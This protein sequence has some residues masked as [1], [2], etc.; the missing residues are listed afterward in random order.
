MKKILGRFLAAI[1]R[2]FVRLFNIGI[3][4]KVVLILILLVGGG[5]FWMTRSKMLEKVGGKEDYDEAMR[6][7][8]IKD[9]VQEHYIDE[10]DRSR[11]GQ[12]A[13][14]AMIAGLGDKW[15]YFMTPDE[16]KSYKLSSANEYSG[17]G[18]SISK[19][20]NGNFRVISVN[21]G[22]AA[23]E[24]G[25]SAGMLLSSVDGENIRGLSEDQARTL[26]RSKLNGK[27]TLGISGGDEL[28]VDC[29]RTHE[30]AVNYRK[31]KTDAGY[32]Q[33]YNFEA[34]SADEAI[35]AIERLLEQNIVALC[36]D[37]RGNAGGLAGETQKL[38][39]YLL[40]AGTLFYTADRKGNEEAASSDSMCIQLPMVVLLNSETYAEAEVFAACMQEYQW[41][42]LFGETTTGSTRDQ[43]TIELSDGSAIRLSTKSYLTP[44]HVDISVKGGVVPDMILYNSDPSTAGTTQGTTGGEQGTASVSND[45]QL[46]AALTFLSKSGA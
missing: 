9:A 34:G 19:E 38:L 23:A 18:M 36:I 30:S 32:V 29:R 10:A 35:D 1:G 22:S 39:D 3:P 27:F 42:T 8:E 12:S 43:E 2:F 25:V 46:M 20:E 37:I 11:M 16:Y 28:E 40:P 44:N 4:L 33:I 26:I 7:I 41:A 45:E 31:E 13:A 24:A 21:P 5:S 6:Y 14:S 17:I 15:S